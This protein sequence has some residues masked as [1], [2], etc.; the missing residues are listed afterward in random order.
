MARERI[1]IILTILIVC[2]GIGLLFKNNI[3]TEQLLVDKK[4]TV[5][6]IKDL[7]TISAII[8]GAVLTYFKFFAGQTFTPKAEISFEISVIETPRKRL[9]HTVK[10]TATNKGNLTI[11]NPVAQIRIKKRGDKNEYP[12]DI[13]QQFGEEHFFDKNKERQTI[14]D[15]GERV[16]FI[17]WREFSSEIYAVTYSTEVSSSSGRKWQNMITVPNKTENTKA[18]KT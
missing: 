4:N 3:I 7:V 13:V 12:E 17:I 16:H 1:V 5:S 2:L 14:I 8:L 9:L 18:D 11:W 6:V 10:V 15:P